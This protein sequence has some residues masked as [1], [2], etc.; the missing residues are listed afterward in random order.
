MSE[1]PVE[2]DKRDFEWVKKE[3]ESSLDDGQKQLWASLLDSLNEDG[4]KSLKKM[5]VSKT[6]ELV[7][8][9]LALCSDLESKMPAKEV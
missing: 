1:E 7:A 4:E 9:G 2:S 3:V 5:L 6:Q 8:E